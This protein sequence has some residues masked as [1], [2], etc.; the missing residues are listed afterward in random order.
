MQAELNT[1]Y[2]NFSVRVNRVHGKLDERSFMEY[3]IEQVAVHQFRMSAEVLQMILLAYHYPDTHAISGNTLLKH[4]LLPFEDA[5][6]AF[7][8]ISRGLFTDEELM[9]DGEDEFIITY[10]AFAVLSTIFPELQAARDHVVCILS[11]AS[12]FKE[13]F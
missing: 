6:T 5:A 11:C 8:G 1:T 3:A 13:M 12:V 7:D 4:G 10:G 9:M 2:C